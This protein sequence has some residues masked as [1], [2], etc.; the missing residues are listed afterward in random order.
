LLTRRRSINFFNRCRNCSLSNNL[1][2]SVICSQPKARMKL[3]VISREPDRPEIVWND[4][5]WLFE[6]KESDKL[7]RP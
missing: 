3:G 5:I 6:N 2:N 1:Q 7:T 4:Q